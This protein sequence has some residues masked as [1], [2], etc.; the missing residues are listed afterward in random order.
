[1]TPMSP[2]PAWLLAAA[3][4]CCSLISELSDEWRFVPRDSE[5]RANE[6]WEK[7]T[8]RKGVQ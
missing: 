5:L 3:A 1:V 7:E 8:D 6:S 2:W 4:P